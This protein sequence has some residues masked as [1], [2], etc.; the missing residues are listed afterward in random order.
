[1]ELR[2][3]LLQEQSPDERVGCEDGPFQPPALW[4]RLEPRAL[5]AV[6]KREAPVIRG[7]FLLQAVAALMLTARSML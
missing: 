1:M 5:Q 7:L 4:D 6:W 3:N 2:P